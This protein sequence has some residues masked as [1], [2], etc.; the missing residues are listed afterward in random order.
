MDNAEES[1]VVAAACLLLSV[2][3]FPLLAVEVL[4]WAFPGPLEWF[5]RIATNFTSILTF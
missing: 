5:S 4:G 1:G 2:L 3:S